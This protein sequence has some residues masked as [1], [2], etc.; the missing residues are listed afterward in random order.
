MAVRS[1]PKVEITVSRVAAASGE[2]TFVSAF[3][4]MINQF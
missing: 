3:L 2:I 4:M 1:E